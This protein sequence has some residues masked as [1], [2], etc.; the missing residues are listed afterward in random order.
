MARKFFYI[1]AGML[2]LAL[3]FHFGASTSTAQGGTVLEGASIQFPAGIPD[4]RATAC[5]NRIY[6][7]MQSGGTPNEFPVPV[8]G[9]S[10]VVATDTYGNVLLENGDW[11]QHNGTAWAYRGNLAGGGPTSTERTTWGQAKS[12]YAPNGG[13]KQSDSDVK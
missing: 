7:W 2:M 8:P 11:F 4:A 10:P 13:T 6:R 5:V 1:S 3:A 12:P 9:T